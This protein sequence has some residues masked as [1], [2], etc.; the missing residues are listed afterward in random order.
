MTT[1]EFEKLALEVRAHFAGLSVIKP[2][3]VVGSSGVRHRFTFLAS[4]GPEL[5]A[6]D[7]CE[8]VGAVEVIR[9]FA[10]SLDAG[11]AACIV[12][13]GGRIDSETLQLASVYGI[14]ILSPGEIQNLFA[15]QAVQVQNVSI[16]LR[17]PLVLEV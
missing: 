15:R 12:N 16:R 2:P 8:E 7:I 11:V 10:K 3:F 4:R 6:F 17:G 9:T 14:R 1:M 13:L 5:F